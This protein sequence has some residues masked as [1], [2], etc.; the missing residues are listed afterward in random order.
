MSDQ[1]EDWTPQL[2]PLEGDLFKWGLDGETGE[3]TVWEVGGPGDGLPTHVTYLETAWGRPPQYDGR[4]VLGYLLADEQGVL[5]VAYQEAEVPVEAVRWA[6][7]RFPGHAL[8][9]S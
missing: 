1:S 9:F 4:D 5:L 6:E 8:R 2:G 7:A 3:F